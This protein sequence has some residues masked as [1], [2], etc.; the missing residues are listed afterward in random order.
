MKTQITT[1][2]TLSL[3]SFYFILLSC[4]TSGKTDNQGKISSQDSVISELNYQGYTFQI[5]SL[6]IKEEL[7]SEE[8]I[9]GTPVCN[10]QKVVIIHDG[11]RKYLNVP[12]PKVEKNNQNGEKVYLRE[13]IIDSLQILWI[14]I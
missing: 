5:I 2:K 12:I 4:Q 13:P 11:I 6:C 10:Y 14:L 1:I 9:A 3:I 8:D 7:N